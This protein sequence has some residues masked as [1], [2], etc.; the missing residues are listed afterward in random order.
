MTIKRSA[1]DIEG[2]SAQLLRENN[3]SSLVAVGN[4]YFAS[5]IVAYEG[6]D[7]AAQLTSIRRQLTE[8]LATEQMTL[9]NVVTTISYTTD[10]QALLE[11]GHV[12]FDAFKDGPPT[13]TYIEVKGLAMSNLLVEVVVTAAR[14]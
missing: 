5:G 9:A 4:L 13:S 12:L 1:P 11:N 7:M 3:I 14:G 10:M 8:L 2:M 6:G